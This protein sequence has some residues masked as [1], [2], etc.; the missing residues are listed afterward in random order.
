MRKSILS[1]AAIASLGFA[2]V[3]S[4]SNAYALERS[5]EPVEEQSEAGGSA[6]LVVLL[7]IVAVITALSAMSGGGD[8]DRPVSP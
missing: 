3:G 4:A 7:S 1:L 6:A 8:D 5:S 2:T